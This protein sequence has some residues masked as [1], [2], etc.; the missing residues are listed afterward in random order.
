MKKS[1]IIKINMINALID[2]D[3][4]SIMT[5]DCNDYLDS[6]LREGFKGYKNQSI[7][8]LRKEC[9]ERFGEGRSNF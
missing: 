4:N 3:I 2:D 8:E 1:E 7:L 5:G 6:I 9:I